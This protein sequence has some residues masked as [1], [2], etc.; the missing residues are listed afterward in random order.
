MYLLNLVVTLLVAI[1]STTALAQE[2]G[3]ISSSA[4]SRCAGKIGLDTREAD[5]AFSAILLDGPWVTIERVE[6]QVGTQTISTVVTGTGARRRRDGT[7]VPFRY[8][9]LLDT[10]GQAVMLHTSHP[11]PQLGDTLPPATMIDGSAAYAETTLPRGAELRIQLLDKSTS[12]PE[13]ILAEQV[14]RIGRPTPIP[15][16]LRVPKDVSLDGRNLAIAARLVVGRQTLFQLKE[17]R[18]VVA[19]DLRKS[20]DLTL[21]K[22]D[23]AKR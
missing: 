9:C 14:V 3:G 11:A 13:E 5:A 7:F 21:E 16:A 10:K 22:V 1:A 6:D 23:Q 20:I 19:D 12:A 2:A 15:F 8:T 18:A 4:I 17:P